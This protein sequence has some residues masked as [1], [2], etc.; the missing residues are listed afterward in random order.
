M[1]ILHI[2]TNDA[3]GA[4]LCC[5]R[6][7]KGLLSKGVESKVLVLNKT[8]DEPELYRFEQKRKKSPFPISLVLPYLEL[9]ARKF[10]GTSLS[11]AERYRERLYRL[12]DGLPVF[13]TLPV[14]DNDLAACSLVPD[15][16]IIHLHWVADFLDYPSFFTKVDK[17]IVW[18]VHD[19]NPYLGGWHYQKARGKHPLLDKFDDELVA[20]KQASMACHKDITIVSLSRMM[21]E[22]SLSQKSFADREH[23]MVHNP[24][25]HSVFRPVDKSFSRELFGL[26]KDKKILCFVSFGLWDARKGFKELLA[27][28]KS[29]GRSDI[30]LCVV[31]A[32]DVKG[33][34][35]LEISSLG[36]VRDDRLMSV[37]YSAADLFV[38]PS[39]QE[40][41]AQSP[42]EAMAC[43]VPVVAF[44]CS[45]T[46]ELI[47]E[48]NGVRTTDFT[49]ES[50]GK[51]IEKAL[52][53]EYDPLWIRN[54]VIERFGIDTI[55]P[56][57]I[58]LY[59]Q[60]LT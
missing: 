14:S 31:G 58:D 33:I 19:E 13:F 56:Q 48:R 55:V 21:R 24:V 7:H 39:F 41:F 15:A 59:R 8:L 37:A 6:I 1:K 27:A 30:A 35:D 10:L 45:G 43:G 18:T 26:P 25:D 4:G 22:F 28:L 40:A 57:Y 36:T 20:I 5:I 53:T 23:R 34:S 44:P 49:V 11:R 52:N 42:L 47:N 3:G 12:R 38:M 29:L 9:T 17:P 60:V 46:G 16:D 54:D 2:S 51:G 50:L 32:G